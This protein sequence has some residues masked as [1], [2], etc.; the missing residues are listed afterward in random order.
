MYLQYLLGSGIGADIIGVDS[1]SGTVN[2]TR[3]V[4]S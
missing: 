1:A 4:V 2:L 3:S